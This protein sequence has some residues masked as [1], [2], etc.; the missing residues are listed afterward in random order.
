MIYSISLTYAFN[1]QGGQV[2]LPMF[3]IIKVQESSQFNTPDKV[4]V[5]LFFWC[6]KC[7]Y[8]FIVIVH[9]VPF[10][11][12]G[13]LLPLQKSFILHV[14]VS[15]NILSCF[16]QILSFTSIHLNKS[17]VDMQGAVTERVYI[18]LI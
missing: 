6:F 13:Y 7:H 9:I 17:D 18:S 10:L 14:T 3:P 16:L 4:D 5:S 8:H 2:H 11:Q 1:L 12:D 15:M